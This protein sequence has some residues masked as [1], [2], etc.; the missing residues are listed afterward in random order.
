MKPLVTFTLLLLFSRIFSQN[1]IAGFEVFVHYECNYS[2]AEYV[3][4]SQYADSFLWNYEGFTSTNFEPRGSNRGGEKTW[5]ATLIAYGNGTSDTL[6][7]EVYINNSRLLF[8]YEILDTNNFAPCTVKYYDKSIIRDGDTIIYNWQFGDGQI[9]DEE[10]P[11]HTYYEPGTY[12][13]NLNGKKNG[14]CT[15]YSLGEPIIV[16]D[17]AQK[18]EFDFIISGCLDESGQ[19]PCGNSKN[20]ELRHDSLIIWG[21]YSGNC[22]TKKTA[23]VRYKGDTVVIQTW[24]VGPETTCGCE[25]CFEIGIPNINTDSVIIIF[26]N[27]LYS[28]KITDISDQIAINDLVLVYP[29][30]SDHNLKVDFHNADNRRLNYE[31]IDLNG[32][33]RQKGLLKTDGI[34][35]L[36]RNKLTVGLYIL[37]LKDHSI[38][39]AKRKIYIK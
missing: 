14:N 25:Y 10:N 13:A 34:I 1:P 9:S 7:K 29:N 23:T 38:I 20:F 24:Q 8:Q 18:D 4:T 26:D 16:R 35:E 21:A 28:V 19:S 17:T 12:F 3:N 2:T 32:M 30:P 27:Q 36:N 6:S 15:M 11:I 37:I 31:I 5:T 22:G 33:I 39:S